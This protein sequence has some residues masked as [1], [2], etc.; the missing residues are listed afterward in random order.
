L[1]HSP[2]PRTPPNS[3]SS[4]SPTASSRERCTPRPST[5]TSASSPP[6]PPVPKPPPHATASAKPPTP[7]PNTTRPSP[8]SIRSSPH[9]P[10]PPSRHAPIS[11]AAKSST[12][13]KSST[14]PAPSSRP[15]PRPKTPPSAPA[16]S[17]TSAARTPT[18]ATPAP[19]PTPSA[20]SSAISATPHSPPTPQY[21]LGFALLAQQQYEDAAVQF[22]AAA[23]SKADDATRA[24][25]RYRAA[26]VYDQIAWHDAAADAYQKLLDEFPNATQRER[27][28]YGLAW[29]RFRGGDTEA[30]RRAAE[31]FDKAY[32][33]SPLRVGTLYL[34]GCALQHAKKY[35]DALAIFNKL[36]ETAA[37]TEFG[38]AAQYRAA[39]VRYLKGEV[40][41]ARDAIQAFLTENPTSPYLGE[42]AF[43]LGTILVGQGDYENAQQQFRLVY[44]KYPRQRVRRRRPLQVRRVPLPA[45]RHRSG[46][47]PL[48]GVRHPLPRE[49]P[50]R[51]GH[52]PRRRRQLQRPGLQG[53]PSRNTARSS[54]SSPPPRSSAR[55][56]TASPSPTTT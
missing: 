48:R 51:A 54:T 34:S 14:T 19:P 43:L 35:D 52:P 55:P 32:P 46:R 28:T 40:D 42:A 1:P 5:N 38:P 15:S 23:A 22:S 44:D 4:T 49:P 33:E 9:P 18:P 8:H 16:P 25:A 27:A 41:P 29:A 53:T 56:S 31:A 13:S 47:H 26:Q 30:G 36:R 3:A 24:E 10:P 20:P 37:Q 6:P 2:K 39:W 45:R 12:T 7:P 17:T 21:Q 50:H 11:P